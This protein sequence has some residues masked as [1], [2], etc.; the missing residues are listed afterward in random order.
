MR[1][2][3]ITPTGGSLADL[4]NPSPEASTGAHFSFPLHACRAEGSTS[5][6]EIIDSGT[7]PDAHSAVTDIDS[8]GNP[9]SLIP[10]A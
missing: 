6:S 5:L 2:R 9:G 4:M 7:I 8:E 3:K 10:R 1:M